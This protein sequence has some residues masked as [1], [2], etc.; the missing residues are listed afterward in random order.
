MN[1]AAWE[2]WVDAFLKAP[3]DMFILVRNEIIVVVYDSVPSYSALSPSAAS[4]T[5]LFLQIVGLYFR[6]NCMQ[7]AHLVISMNNR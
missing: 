6:R 2:A 4:S 1:T 7:R 3:R 5:C